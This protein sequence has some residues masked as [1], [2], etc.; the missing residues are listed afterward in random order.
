MEWFHKNPGSLDNIHMYEI[1]LK[2]QKK[3][4]PDMQNTENSNSATKQK[5]WN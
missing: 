3:E 5:I 4:G 2:M 1:T